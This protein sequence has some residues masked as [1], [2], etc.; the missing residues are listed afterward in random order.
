MERRVSEGTSAFDRTYSSVDRRKSL[1]QL[2]WTQ[3]AA[4]VSA[5]RLGCLN[6]RAEPRWMI[7]CTRSAIT[8]IR[9]VK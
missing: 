9:V 3:A 8:P 4:S 7:W 5:T 6:S 1:G 2:S